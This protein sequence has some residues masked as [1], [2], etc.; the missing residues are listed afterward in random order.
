MQDAINEFTGTPEEIRYWCVNFPEKNCTPPVEDNDFLTKILSLCS[1]TVLAMFS[2]IFLKF[3]YIFFGYPQFFGKGPGYTQF[4]AFPIHLSSL[5]L[6]L[7]KFTLDWGLVLVSLEKKF[8][9][10]L[11]FVDFEY[12]IIVATLPSLGGNPSSWDVKSWF[13]SFQ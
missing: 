11:T 2:L 7:M 5:K 4:H 1:L 12:V 9:L 10:R 6:I 8:S 13:P 3:W